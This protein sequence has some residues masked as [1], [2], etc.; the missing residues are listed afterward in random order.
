MELNLP[1]GNS[2]CGS[3]L[4]F[5]TISGNPKPHSGLHCRILVRVTYLVTRILQCR[6]GREP[7]VISKKEV[8]GAQ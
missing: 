4:H 6:V 2:V 8:G 3:G 7:H 1:G 5:S